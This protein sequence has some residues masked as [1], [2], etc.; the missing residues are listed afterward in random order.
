M[1]NNE[2]VNQQQYQANMIAV[3]EQLELIE[4]GVVV[5]TSGTRFCCRK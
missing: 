3:E 2:S 4:R 5:C 1:Q